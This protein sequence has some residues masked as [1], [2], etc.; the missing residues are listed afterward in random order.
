LRAIVCEELGRARNERRGEDRPEDRATVTHRRARSRP[1][2][3]PSRCV[4][5]QRSDPAIVRVILTPVRWS[6]VPSTCERFQVT[7]TCEQ[8]SPLGRSLVLDA[9]PGMRRHRPSVDLIRPTSSLRVRCNAFVDL[10]IHILSSEAA[11]PLS[12]VTGRRLYLSGPVCM[13]RSEST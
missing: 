8:R 5:Q 3:A 10:P 4:A 6:P 13:C 7:P 11:A 1:L 9:D 12:V 2:S